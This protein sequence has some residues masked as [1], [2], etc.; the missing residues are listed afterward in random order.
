MLR[1]KTELRLRA[2]GK[3][4]KNMAVKRW[5]R[6]ASWDEVPQVMGVSELMRVLQISKPTALRYLADGIIPA[7]KVGREWRIDR[8]AVRAFLAGGRDKDM[9]C[10]A[11]EAACYDGAEAPCYGMGRR[12]A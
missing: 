3:D 5:T 7:A 8:D 2:T 9:R 10:N 6:V 11:A 4:G 12:T 1:E